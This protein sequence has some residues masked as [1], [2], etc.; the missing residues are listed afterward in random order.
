MYFKQEALPSTSKLVFLI[1]FTYST[2]I[3]K[4]KKI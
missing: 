4:Y 3:H 2:K 1:Y